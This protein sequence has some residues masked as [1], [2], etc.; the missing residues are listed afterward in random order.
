MFS[1]STSSW[2]TH[3]LL[4]QVR[5][6]HNIDGTSFL[7]SG[8]PAAGMSLLDLPAFIAKDGIP[9]IEIC[10]FH[11]PTINSDY[12]AQLK[13]AL[14]DAGLTLENILIDRGNL[15]DPDDATWRAEIELGK[16][17]FRITADLGGNGCRVDCGTEPP[18]P[19]AK[20]RSAAALQEL[21]DYAV[22]L[23][24]KLTTEN[25]RQTSVQPDDLL[26][27]ISMVDRPLNLCVDFGNANK[28]SDKFGTLKKLMPLGTSIHCKGEYADGQLD[29]AD[30]HQALALMGADFAGFVTLIVDETEREWEKTLELRDAIDQYFSEE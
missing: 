7:K 13:N 1:F 9:K 3:G 25:F 27:I 17:W 12:V 24:I 16:M 21:A 5:Y 26:E 11:L 29:R 20:A 15:S 19:A 6:Q 23:G 10:H 30:L 22:T 28:T 4:G 8:D 14:Q 18:T 2:T